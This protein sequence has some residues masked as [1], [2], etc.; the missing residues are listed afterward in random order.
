MF[1]K[2]QHIERFGTVEVEN[3]QYGVCY[4]F[5]K[6]DGTN[7]SVWLEN[8]EI[9]A[10]SR[11]RQLDLEQDNADFYK[12]I[13]QEEKIAH[14]LLD[15]P[16]WRIF[17]EWLVPHT[18]KTYRQD[19]WRKFYVFDIM[20]EDSYL[21]YEEYAPILESYGIEFIRPLA[22]IN[23][24]SYDQLIGLL[25]TNTYLI[26]DGKGSGE[27]II[28]KNYDYQNKFGRQ[29]WAK[30]V[31]SEFKDSHR[32]V[33]GVRPTNGEKIVES[34][35][36]NSYCTKELIEKVYA[37]IVNENG[38]WSSK[39]IPQLLNVVYYDLI[40]E[41]TWDFVKEYKF[42]IINFKAL[43]FLCVNKIKETKPELF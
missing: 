13:L 19:S 15:Y 42:P 27:G 7:S 9:K 29:T 4:I 25:D 1:K 34:E 26:E 40:K 33:M 28:I 2:Y 31:R 22:I 12:S 41:E 39:K 16:F 36:I 38:G 21:Y 3:I 11:T 32:K 23:N 30:I 6:I 10:G 37:K 14:L 8:L 35:I 20:I 18:L 5:P 17:G 24:P 43:Q